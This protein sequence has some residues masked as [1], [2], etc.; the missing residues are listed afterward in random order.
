MQIISFQA[1]AFS[2]ARARLTQSIQLYENDQ[3][4][5]PAL[6]RQTKSGG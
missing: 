3:Q 5:S 6:T 1:D 2:S 4:S